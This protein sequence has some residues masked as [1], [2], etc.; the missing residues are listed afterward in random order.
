MKIQDKPTGRRSFIKE[1][2]TGLVGAAFMPFLL[3]SKERNVLTQ[4]GKEHWTSP[5]STA[6]SMRYCG[7][8]R[9]R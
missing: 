4:T 1:S 9:G 3:K 7:E 2:M 5:S 6:R 8:D